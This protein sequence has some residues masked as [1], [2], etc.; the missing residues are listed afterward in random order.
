[1]KIYLSSYQIPQFF[2]IKYFLIWNGLS[3]D[4]KKYEF[5]YSVKNVIL[6]KI[7]VFQIKKNYYKK[8]KKNSLFFLKNIV[9]TE[10]HI[11]LILTYFS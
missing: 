5:C 9:R 8:N 1:M 10:K 11:I 2:K 4:K 7:F 6:K 3:K